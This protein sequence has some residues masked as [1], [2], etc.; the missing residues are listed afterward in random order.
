M[1]TL[2]L[3]HLDPIRNLVPPSNV[4]E[5]RR[6]LGLFVVSRKCI[7][8]FAIITRPMTDMLKGKPTS[9]A[10]GAEQQLAFD[11]VR[12]KLLAGVHL[13]SPDF[14]LPFHLATDA[15]E[16]GK[17]GE[18]YQLPTIPL[19]QQYSYCPKLH[20]PENHAVIFFLSK[21]FTDTQR[22]KPP[23]YLE[24]DALLWCTHKCRYYAFSSRFP[25]YTYSDHMPL[26]WMQ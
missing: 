13:A 15:S 8:D 4:Y 1:L 19:I 20:A 23:L 6:V 18:L 3:K 12:D 26:N 25:L 21:A 9:F 11:F 17:G 14:D 22:L 5:L 24:G 2:V 16:D 10:W 7:K